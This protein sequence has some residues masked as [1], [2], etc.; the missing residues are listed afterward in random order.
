MVKSA[1][2]F[3]AS[4]GLGAVEGAI[5]RWVSEL[6]ACFVLRGR[7]RWSENGDFSAMGFWS[8]IA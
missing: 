3:G 1:T 2:V 6:L 7:G 4:L 8:V 5:V